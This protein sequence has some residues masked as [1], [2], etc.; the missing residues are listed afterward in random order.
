MDSGHFGLGGTGP[1]LPAPAKPIRAPL[2]WPEVA[3]CQSFQS[4]RAL[5]VMQVGRLTPALE[6]APPDSAVKQE[7]QFPTLFQRLAVICWQRSQRRLFPVMVPKWILYASLL[8]CCQF[9]RRFRG[10]SFSS[11]IASFGG[12]AVRARFRGRDAK[13]CRHQI[14]SVTGLKMPF[15]DS[16]R[17]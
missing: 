4:W 12:A 3:A 6:I 17:L 14:G 11:L 2:S 15:F 1:A 10:D 5:L 8:Q 9:S 13:S 16:G 7:Q